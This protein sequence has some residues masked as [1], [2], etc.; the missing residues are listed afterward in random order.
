VRIVVEDAPPFPEA[1]ALST[2]VS[3]V[4]RG[5]IAVRKL[6]PTQRGAH[7]HFVISDDSRLRAEIDHG[8]KTAVIALNAADLDV[9]QQHAA[10]FEKLFTASEPLAAAQ[11]NAVE[12]SSEYE[13]A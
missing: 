5:L 12:A 3:E 4:G 13:T 2:L 7:P 10:L 1:S 8:A 11:L 9:F 6:P